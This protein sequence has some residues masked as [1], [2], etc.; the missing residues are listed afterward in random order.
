MVVFI[1]AIL[2]FAIY[3]S[4]TAIERSQKALGFRNSLESVAQNARNEA[5]HNNRA[6]QIKF[7]NDGRIGWDYAEE[8]VTDAQTANEP[9]IELGSVRDGITPTETTEFS[10][11]Q[12]TG[13]TVTQSDWKVGFYPDGS[14]DRAYLEF[15]MDGQS[16]VL[17]VN[18]ESGSSAIVQSTISEQEKH[19]W[20]AGEIERRVG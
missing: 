1:I 19:E 17:T 4:I 20:P 8:A 9:E 15:T 5:I 18:P 14:A 12:L 10:G 3:P 13:A 6:T 16:Y 2:S 11:Y 7:D